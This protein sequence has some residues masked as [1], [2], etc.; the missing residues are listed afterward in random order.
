MESAKPER[1]QPV[2][3]VFRPS[4]VENN[5]CPHVSLGSS[6]TGV[7]RKSPKQ[8]RTEIQ[9]L[10]AD[11]E[12]IRDLLVKKVQNPHEPLWGIGGDCSRAAQ[13]LGNILTNQV[14]PDC[15]KVAVVGRFKAGK[16]SFVNE[17]LGARLAGEDTSPETAA[18]TTFQHGDSVK[19]TIRFISGESWQN[20]RARYQEDPKHIDAH[21]VKMWE[22]F[23]DKPRKNADGE[24]GGEP[25]R[26]KA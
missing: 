1:F 10:R 19:A 15:Y 9:T 4:K 24:T 18:V 16:S 11:V 13:A 8:I 22:S 14:I 23:T 5:R 20:L 2:R 26:P 3:L 21:R 25:R 17:L 12:A 6:S 7:M